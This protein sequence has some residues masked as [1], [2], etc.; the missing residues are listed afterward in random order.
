MVVWLSV[1]T[2]RVGIG[3][4]RAV[5]HRVGPNRLRQIFEIDLVADAGAGRHDA[6]ILERA[7]APLQEVIALAVARIFK[8]HVLAERLRRAEFID[9]DRVVD[10]EIDGHQRIDLV[11]IAAELGHAVA[12]GGEIDDGWNAGEILHQHA[13]RAEADFLAGLASC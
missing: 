6:E 8:R 4:G 5:G 2:T 13:G 1:P 7:L 3:D 9:D 12:H 11:G 10:D